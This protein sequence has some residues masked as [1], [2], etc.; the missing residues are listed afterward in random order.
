M[1]RRRDGGGGGGLLRA[2]EKAC[3]SQAASS[4]CGGGSVLH[5]SAGWVRVRETGWGSLAREGRHA[6]GYGVLGDVNM[7]HCQSESA[8]WSGRHARGFPEYVW[9]RTYPS[10]SPVPSRAVAGRVES[11]VTA[12][13]ATLPVLHHAR[14]LVITPAVAAEAAARRY[15]T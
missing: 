10:P 5:G 11:L 12:R 2:R 4:G 15:G 8:G 14:S 1:S 7:F 13:V 9:K 6:R 3:V